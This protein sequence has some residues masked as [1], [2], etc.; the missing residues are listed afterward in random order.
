MAN[1][2]FNNNPDLITKSFSL[3]YFIELIFLLIGILFNLIF[4]VIV[5]KNIETKSFQSRKPMAFLLI[6]ESNRLFF[7][8][9]SLLI[10]LI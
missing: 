4:M 9:A 3:N 5:Y 1:Q 8:I 7:L 10:N 2:N 6:G